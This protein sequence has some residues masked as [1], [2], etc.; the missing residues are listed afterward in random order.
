MNKPLIGVTS[1]H[2]NEED[3]FLL[4]AN[5]LDEVERAGGIPVIIPPIGLDVPK[6]LEKLDGIILSGGVDI[7]PAEYGGQYKE[8]VYGVN[9]ERDHYELKLAALALENQVP[10]LAICRGLQV[11][12]VALGGSLVEH[13]PDEYGES[14]LHR[15]E[16]LNKVEHP[17]SIEADSRLARIIGRTAFNCPS[18]HHQ[19]IRMTAPQFK[20]VAQSADG[21]IEA[22]ESE[23]YRKVIAVQWHPEYT[24]KTDHSQRHLF[25]ALVAW[26]RGEEFSHPAD[27]ELGRQPVRDVA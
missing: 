17:V 13:I 5:Y 20:V 7:D 10:T 2:R 16:N 18:F 24:A 14:V 12:N 6:I 9:S 19:C 4:P 8:E 23:Q 22:I 1:H 26:S 11:I 27:A 3:R 21:V 25:S 15:G